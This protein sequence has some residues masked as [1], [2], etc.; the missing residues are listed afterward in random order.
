MI[1]DWWVAHRFEFVVTGV[2]FGLAA[3][4]FIV[5]VL[6]SRRGGRKS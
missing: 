1:H 6:V 2:F 5:G 4:A 3:V